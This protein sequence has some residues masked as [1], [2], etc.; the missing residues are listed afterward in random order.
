MSHVIYSIISV[1][2]SEW[3]AQ[4]NR[5]SAAGFDQGFQATRHLDT[6]L[7]LYP[8]QSIREASSSVSE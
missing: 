6:S 2:S 3:P 5:H 4:A 1:H 8:A 7:L